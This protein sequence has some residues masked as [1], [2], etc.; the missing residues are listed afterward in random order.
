MLFIFLVI[1][2]LATTLVRVSGIFL[3]GVRAGYSVLNGDT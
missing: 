3:G 1:A 2:F